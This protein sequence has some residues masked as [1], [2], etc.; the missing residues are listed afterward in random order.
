[1]SFTLY[2]L[3]AYKI[4]YFSILDLLGKGFLFLL[5]DG[6]CVCA[7]KVFLSFAFFNCHYTVLA[8]PFT[9]KL[10]FPKNCANISIFNTVFS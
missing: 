7:W 10:R 6:G 2:S 9:G 4:S 8:K 1:M 3:A 5:C